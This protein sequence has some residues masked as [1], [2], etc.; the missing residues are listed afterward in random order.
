MMKR[1]MKAMVSLTES[2]VSTTS[3][4][5]WISTHPVIVNNKKI[6]DLKTALIEI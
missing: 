4:Q 6:L 3:S 1:V 5:I 2:Q